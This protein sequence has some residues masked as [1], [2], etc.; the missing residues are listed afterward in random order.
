MKGLDS[1][2]GRLA[3][4]MSLTLVTVDTVPLIFTEIMANYQQ[5]RSAIVEFL[6]SCIL[7]SCVRDWS[8]LLAP[9]FTC[10]D[11]V[12]ALPFAFLHSNM[13]VASPLAFIFHCVVPLR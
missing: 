4:L 11:W 9:S 3:T 6:H 8:L 10:W 7:A 12:P 13:R 5:K 1:F 2:G